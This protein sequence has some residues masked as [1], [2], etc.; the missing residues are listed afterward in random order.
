M[1][2]FI[3]HGEKLYDNGKGI[4]RFDPGIKSVNIDLRHFLPE[5]PDLVISSPFLRCRET[6]KVFYPDHEILHMSIYCEYLGHWSSISKEDFDQ[7]TIKLIKDEKY[8]SSLNDILTRFSKETVKDFKKRMVS[9]KIDPFLKYDSIVIITHGFCLSELYTN[10]LKDSTIKITLF[11]DNPKDGFK[12]EKIPF[13]DS[14]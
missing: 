6:A 13:D 3:R 4:P 7:E 12:I 2:Y 10:F 1:I 14:P 9:T 8:S 5:T 11:N